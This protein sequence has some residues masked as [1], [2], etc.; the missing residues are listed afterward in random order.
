MT[1]R[2][3]R[4]EVFLRNEGLDKFERDVLEEV[5]DELCNKHFEQRAVNPEGMVMRKELVDR[6]SEEAKEVIKIIFN[7]PSELVGY[8]WGCKEKQIDK[9]TCHDLRQYLRYYGWK[10]LVIE[11]VFQEIRRFLKKV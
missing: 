11:S 5:F 9:L 6:L 1:E 8:I 7:M 4:L 10:Y 2:M 3:K